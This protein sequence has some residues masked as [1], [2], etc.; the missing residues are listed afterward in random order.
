MIVNIITKENDIDISQSLYAFK[1][2]E[3]TVLGFEYSQLPHD[4]DWE[5]VDFI[6]AQQLSQRNNTQWLK[7]DNPT[8]GWKYLSNTLN[9]WI[10]S[11][12]GK[13]DDSSDPSLSAL[14][15][16]KINKNRK[17]LIDVDNIRK[18][19]ARNNRRGW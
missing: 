14:S 18:R 3:D 8:D 4:Y 16:V 6:F 7:P 5:I 15:A 19:K 10:N 11:F 2:G 13:L 1:S 9:S 17:T 12:Q